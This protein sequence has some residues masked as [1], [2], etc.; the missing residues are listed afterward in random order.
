LVGLV[1]RDL[2]EILARIARKYIH[3]VVARRAELIAGEREQMPR[4]RVKT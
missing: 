3:V 1:K 2:I 4:R